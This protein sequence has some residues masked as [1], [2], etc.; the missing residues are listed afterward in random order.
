[1]ETIET[2]ETVV[3]VQTVETVE[4]LK[5]EDLKARD[6]SAFKNCRNPISKQGRDRNKPTNLMIVMVLLA[7]QIGL[8]DLKDRSKNRMEK[9]ITEASVA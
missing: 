1:M 4:T 3:T 2:V 8:G 9:P 5:T 7:H 6:A